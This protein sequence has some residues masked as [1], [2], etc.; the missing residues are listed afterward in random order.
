MLSPA[1]VTTPLLGFD[2][3][4]ED[5]YDS[6]GLRK[7]DAVFL[8]ALTESDPALRARLNAARQNPL[9]LA[10]KDEAELLLALAAPL[11]AF[12]AR[13][14]RIETE[15]EALRAR[16]GKL[17]PL[18]SCKR[19]FVQRRVLKASEPQLATAVDGEQL[20]QDLSTRFGTPFSELAF[21][22]HVERWLQ[23]ESAHVA[24]I[25]AATRYTAWALHTEAGR[26]KHRHG[27]LFKAPGKLRHEHL[28][29]LESTAARGFTEHRAHAHHLRRREGF[30]LTDAGTD[31]TGALDEA[32]YCIWCHHQSKDSCSKGL[33]EKAAPDTNTIT[34]K[35]S[36]FGIPLAGCPLEERISEFQELKTQGYSIAALAVITVDNPMVAATGHR[37]CNDC[38]KACI[39]QKQ[40]PVDIPQAETRTLKDVLELPWGFEIYSLL[41]RW[42]PLNLRNRCR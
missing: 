2:L 11:E 20:T 33:R 5:L 39:Y 40:E 13:L 16:H 42:N 3:R 18:Y 28:V 24:D 41:T 29:P 21:A 27:V 12:I 1:P 34:F 30:K 14:F 19:H 6:Q 23:D 17:G 35:K 31:I 15:A 7:V 10:Q 4:F 8:A 9:A 25:D 38:M 37:I 32:N 22:E 36:P 26:D